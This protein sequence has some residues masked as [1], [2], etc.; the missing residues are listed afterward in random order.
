MLKTQKSI[1]HLP[2]DQQEQQ[3]IITEELLATINQPLLDEDIDVIRQNKAKLLEEEYKPHEWVQ[4]K[5]AKLKENSSSSLDELTTI[6]PDSITINDNSITMGLEIPSNNKVTPLQL[7]FFQGGVIKLHS[8]NP[9]NPSKFSFEMIDKPVDLTPF[10]LQGNLNIEN[11]HLEVLLSQ[12]NLKITLQFNPFALTI[13]ST[14]TDQIFAEFNPNK[15]FKFD[16]NL[17]GD[18]KFHTQYVYGLAE[19]AH[20]LLLQDTTS[21]F[22]YRM[23]NSDR[24]GYNTY[25][26]DSLYGSIPLITGKIPNSSAYISA[27]WQNTSETYVDIHKKKSSSNTFWISERGNLEVYFITGH[28][29]AEHS[30]N[31]AKVLGFAAM[32][33]LFTLGYHQCRYSYHNEQDLLHVNQNFNKFNL[34]CDSLTLDIDHTDNFKYFTWSTDL[35]PDPI[36]LQNDLAKD[37]RV[38][39]TINDPH[40]SVDSDYFIF[41]EAQTKKLYV[42]KPDSEPFVGECFPGNCIW[43]DYLNPETQEFWSSLY[44]YQ[45]YQFSTPNLFAWN[46]MNEP[47]LFEQL[48][49]S[50]PKDNLHTVVDAS[51]NPFQVQHREVHNIYGYCM[52]KST[53]LGLINRN[54][55][56][57]IRPH[58]LSRSFFAGSQKYTTVW[59][60]DTM[61]TWEH[62]RVTVPMMLSMALCGVSFIGGD[63]GGFLGNPEP[64]LLVRWY[65]LGSFMPYFRG[66]SDKR[67]DRREPWLV[68]EEYFPIIKESIREKYR[69]LQ[70]WYT[71]FEEYCRTGN[72]VLRPIWWNEEGEVEEEMMKEEERYMIGDGILVVPVLK[73]GQKTIKHGLKGRWYDYYEKKEVKE[74]EEIEVG[75]ER[76]GVFVKGGKIIPQYEVKDEVKS[77]K[78][79]KENGEMIVMVALDEEEKAKGEIYFDDGET[80][81]YKKGEFSR[82][83]IEFREGKLVWKEEGDGRYQ[84]KNKVKKI[85]MVGMKRNGVKIVKLLR[86]NGKM[87]ELKISEKNGHLE[88]EVD[89][90]A[91]ENWSI[92][93]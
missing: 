61:S 89:V 72:P 35:F 71:C 24:L 20:N 55:D 38:L 57:N 60:G 66:H 85:I 18:I 80:F 62:L 19:R 9:V 17:S 33:Q 21:S 56:Q 5:L 8:I 48:D 82:K 75:I 58:V 32:P 3:Q 69:L 93:F 44:Q 77:S 67:Y 49:K 25:S 13:F 40:I 37:G 88:I 63:V 1:D 36:K 79:L 87:E 73:E 43:L 64:E 90:M 27:F 39:L 50:M 45:N 42:Q 22:P 34:P 4:S 2:D 7:T 26:K 92:E 65:Q 15:S 51:G 74:G 81:G 70:Y 59:T 16:S 46:D 78:D 11:D 91:N 23:Y 41:K 52:H 76:I 6:R 84:V 54:E 10:S 47:S 68:D 83:V 31:L 14:S 29:P 28:S 53:Y 12:E 30:R 86:E